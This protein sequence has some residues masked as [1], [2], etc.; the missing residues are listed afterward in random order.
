MALSANT[1]WAAG[2]YVVVARHFTG[3]DKGIRFPRWGSTKPTNKHGQRRYM[4]S[5][6]FENGKVK[7]RLDVLQRRRVRDALGL[8]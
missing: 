5:F 1:V 8:K 4:R 2:D 7:R 6:K 3:T